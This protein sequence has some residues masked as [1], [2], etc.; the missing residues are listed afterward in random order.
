SST[1][2]AGASIGRT[3]DADPHLPQYHPYW[4]TYDNP[5]WNPGVQAGG[6]ITGTVDA[7]LDVSRVEAAGMVQGAITAGRDVGFVQGILGVSASIEA[8]RDIGHI[9]AGGYG[10]I[11]NYYYSYWG[12][13]PNGAAGTISGQIAALGDIYG[14]FAIGDIT[15]TVTA[16]GGIADVS[17]QGSITGG[18]T[19]GDNIG[20]LEGSSGSGSGSGSGFGG[21]G[22]W[23]GVYVDAEIAAG[24]DIIGVRAGQD[25]A[26]TIQAGRDLGL[27]R[28]SHNLS[29]TITAGRDIGALSA[30]CLSEYVYPTGNVP[31]I[32]GHITS[33]ASAGR[34]I[35]SVTAT[36]D[37]D[38]TITAGHAI[39]GVY[40]QGQI[41]GTIQ[42]TTGTI[43][44]LTDEPESN[45]YDPYESYR[46]PYSS[47]ANAPGRVHADGDINATITA[48]LDITQVEAKGVIAGSITSGR[49][50][51]GVV[52]EHSIDANISAVRN[53][54]VI[55]AGLTAP[56]GYYD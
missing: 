39:G 14:V 35:R 53:I 49:D 42:A 9:Y 38:A 43:G 6:D 48:G 29:A 50:I 24:G 51:T 16:G 40:A 1:I 26:G 17:A 13:L 54:A 5:Y 47:E 3:D 20:Y 7:G 18:I 8:M 11:D 55:K 2:T 44:R 46:F 27:A 45:P 19:A 52:A 4:S 36:G 21:G 25:I 30:G 15:G 34:D 41:G 33:D 32:T 56:P 10:M 22:I 12:E 23:A 37:I 28:A 31:G